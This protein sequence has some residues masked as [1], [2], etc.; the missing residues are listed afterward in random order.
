[1]RAVLSSPTRSQTRTLSRC[2]MINVCIFT[3]PSRFRFESHC[4]D[5]II[6]DRTTHD[7][8]ATRCRPTRQPKLAAEPSG[9]AANLRFWCVMKDKPT[10]A[11]PHAR[12]R[13]NNFVVLQTLDCSF[14]NA[15]CCVPHAVCDG[16]DQRIIAKAQWHRQ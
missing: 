1:M 8:L 15:R 4:N 16:Q 10:E 2:F 9:M 13:L 11:Y 7:A 6:Y 14:T 3:A 12:S 5:K